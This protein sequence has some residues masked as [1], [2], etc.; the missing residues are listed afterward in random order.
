MSIIS[1]LKN[2]MF[3]NRT[4]YKAMYKGKEITGCG[5]CGNNQPFPGLIAFAPTHKCIISDDG[6]GNM[7][8]IFDPFNIPEF[9]PLKYIEEEH[10]E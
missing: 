6:S 7:M 1:E 3:T 5:D 4:N 9:C 2:A 8:V 10:K